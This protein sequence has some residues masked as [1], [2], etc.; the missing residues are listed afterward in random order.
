MKKR[1]S[2]DGRTPSPSSVAIIVGRMYR[3]APSSLGIHSRSSRT[4][5]RRAASWS[6][7]GISG[8]HMRA[9]ERFMRSAFRSGRKRQT[10]PS[11]AKYAFIPSKISCP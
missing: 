10:A 5:A 6:S 3:E 7:T 11:R 8:R 9:A 4:R 2:A 1:T